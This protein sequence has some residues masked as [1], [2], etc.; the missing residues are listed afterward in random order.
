MGSLLWLELG[1]IHRSAHTERSEGRRKLKSRVRVFSLQI[2]LCHGAR[3]GLHPTSSGSCQLA[4]SIQWPSLCSSNCFLPLPFMPRVLHYPL[5]I[6]F[7][8]APKTVNSSFIK[9]SS[10]SQFECV[11]CFLPELWLIPHPTLLTIGT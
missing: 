4:Q 7:N 11:S 8:P 1:F 6:S 3:D 9:P 2:P 10:Q 5:F